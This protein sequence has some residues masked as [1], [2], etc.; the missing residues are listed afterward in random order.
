MDMSMMHPSS[1]DATT[2]EAP[3]APRSSV[4]QQ[5][6]VPQ[7]PFYGVRQTTLPLERVFEFLNDR[8]LYTGH[9]GFR[10]GST[11]TAEH[12]AWL[13]ATVGGVLTA[14]KSQALTL[15][16]VLTPRVSYGYFSCHAV[17]D[18]LQ[19]FASPESTEVL[20]Q[21]DL[22]RGGAKN[23][24]LVDYVRPAESGER[25]VIAL[26]LVTMGSA[27]GEFSHQLLQQQRYRD[28]F[29]FHGFS[30]E[31][32][33]ALAEAWHAETRKEWGISAVE[34][35]KAPREL[36]KPSAY[37]GCRYSFGYPAC[38][39]LE[40][41]IKLMGLL[42]P[43]AVGVVLSAGLMLVP[44]Q[45]TSALVFHHREAHYFDVGSGMMMM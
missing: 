1:D 3:P 4:S 27:A 32:A 15:S 41:Q 20:A 21:F 29:F 39:N 38:P 42:Q 31:L 33:E 22:P 25:D 2:T 36:M 12:E 34:A 43:D 7:P 13:D 45:S 11:P 37:Q 10:R 23:L 40:D 18:S 24:C 19:L 26:Q 5:E 8:V 6:A 44:E 35:G 28:Y 17:G 16:D 9:W 30:V 14:L